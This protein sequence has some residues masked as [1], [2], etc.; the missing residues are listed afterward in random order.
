VVY[1]TE[2][3]N[4]ISE[5]IKLSQKI[6]LIKDNSV[7]DEIFFEYQDNLAKFNHDFR[8]V[9]INS[10]QKIINAV[11]DLLLNLGIPKNQW[12]RYTNSP[13]SFYDLL[14]ELRDH[15]KNNEGVKLII[16]VIN[17]QHKTKWDEL[18]IT[19][20]GGIL[21]TSLFYQRLIDLWRLTRIQEIIAGALFVP[22]VGIVYTVGVGFYSLYQSVK[23][24][25]QSF[26]EK[27]SDNFFLLA[28]SV[29]KI[30]AYGL[31]LSAA[32]YAA[33]IAAIL[34]VASSVFSI[35]KESLSLII[36]NK[37]IKK[38]SQISTKLN[39]SDAQHLIRLKNDKL[40]HINAVK[41]NV[42]EAAL[43]TGIVAAMCFVPGGLIVTIPCVIA[44]ILVSII[45]MV[46]NKK[47]KDLRRVQLGEEF[48]EY[49]KKSESSNNLDLVDNLESRVSPNDLLNSSKRSLEISSK[50]TSTH[51]KTSVFG[52]FSSASSKIKQD[53]KPAE[54]ELTYSEDRISCS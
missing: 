41:L 31:S 14:I 45:K 17:N 54:L 9:A 30:A 43:M 48:S 32:M 52:F 1:L 15:Y 6:F 29:L 47:D 22:I 23:N 13:L 42:A 36:N 28:G 37:E 25:D 11:N 27:F 20:S 40:K 8:V 21:T 44:M 39:L 49:E 34:F 5:Y 33:P 26:V 16:N 19:G 51:I 46:I 3:I 12:T 18:F 4:D 50:A 24:K 7:L 35:F 38:L 10:N 2:K 53:I